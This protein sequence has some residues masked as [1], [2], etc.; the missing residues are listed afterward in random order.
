MLNMRIQALFLL[1][2]KLTKR[3]ADQGHETFN[4]V[5]GP[6]LASLSPSEAGKKIYLFYFN[7]EE[8]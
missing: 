5:L 7:I 6:F 2:L 4:A 8:D 3:G 1:C